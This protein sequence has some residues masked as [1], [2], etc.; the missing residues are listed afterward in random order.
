MLKTSLIV[1]LNYFF[2]ALSLL[3][4]VPPGVLLEI[5]KFLEWNDLCQLSRTCTKFRD[6]CQSAT[7]W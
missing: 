6:I 3:E 5:F 2:S 7:L 4:F 1:L